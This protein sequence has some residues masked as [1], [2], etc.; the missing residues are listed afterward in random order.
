[1]H[2]AS[3]L[4]TRL[5]RPPTLRS[6]DELGDSLVALARGRVWRED[7]GDSANNRITFHLPYVG[8]RR[9][10]LL[11]GWEALETP[12]SPSHG[13]PVNLGAKALKIHREDG[14]HMKNTGKRIFFSIVAFGLANLA[15]VV[16]AGAFT[17][18]R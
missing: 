3:R 6:P 1:M 7:T 17:S 8:L 18:Q 9:P 4:L 11:Q 2:M 10:I 16:S 15:I 13:E 5:R 12:R 14:I